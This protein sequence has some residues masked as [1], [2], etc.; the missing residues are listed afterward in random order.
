MIDFIR[1]T[2]WSIR[3]LVRLGCLRRGFHSPFELFTAAAGARGIA[4]WTTRKGSGP[5]I[6]I[7]PGRTTTRDDG[8]CIAMGAVQRKVNGG[9]V[10][11][12]IRLLFR[13]KLIKGVLTMGL[14]QDWQ[15]SVCSSSINCIKSLSLNIE[16]TVYDRY[17]G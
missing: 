10:N 7:L 2:A 8:V 3:S 5:H 13:R 15:V 11:I 12:E 1:P 16:Q 6:A 4:G 9:R 14:P 17:R